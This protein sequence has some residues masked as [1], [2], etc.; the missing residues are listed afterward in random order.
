MLHCNQ[1]IYKN[2]RQHIRTFIIEELKITSNEKKLILKLQIYS[3]STHLKMEYKLYVCVLSCFS[4]VQLFATLWTVACQTPLTMGFSS[5]NTE[6]GCH[7]LPQEVFPTLGA[8]LQLS[9]SHWQ[10]GSLPLAPP[11]K[12]YQFSSVT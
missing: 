8:N 11:G 1:A 10:A 6:V 12:L 9:T 7:A 4:H 5:K 3:L 2:L